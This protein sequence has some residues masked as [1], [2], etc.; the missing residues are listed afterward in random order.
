MSRNKYPQAALDDMEPV[1][2][3]KKLVTSFKDLA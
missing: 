1:E 3:V 2:V